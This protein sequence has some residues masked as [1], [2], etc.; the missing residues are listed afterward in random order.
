MFYKYILTILIFTS[1]SFASFQNVKIGRIDSYYKNKISKEELKTIIE[2]IEIFFES[3]L[4]INVFD[5][6]ATGKSINLVYVP[7]SKLENRIL[8]YVQ[9]L[10]LKEKEI[11]NLHKSFPMKQKNIDK[12]KNMF[13]QQN[14]LLN[15]RVKSLNDYVRTVNKKKKISKNEYNDVQRYVKKEKR[16]LEVGIKKLRKEEQSIK[17]R[18]SSFNKSV[19]SYNNLILVHKRLNS[20]LEVMSRGFKKVK[21]MTFGI[22][23]IRLKTFYKNGKKVKEKSVK[24]SMN[25]I[26][27]YGFETKG[28]LKAI[29]A[30]EILHLVGIPHI[31]IKNSLMHPV[32][33]KNQI[34]QIN[35]PKADILNFKKYF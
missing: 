31:N 6:S 24:N 3:K 18:V 5:Y 10:K 25:K 2:E 16:K 26:D 8:D 17:K 13:V 12:L 20:Q 22:K 27:I 15:K 9:K 30:H 14:N 35:L 33:Q 7:A 4:N 29:L 11:T 23:E 34:K 32:L 19:Y 21:G 28:E 1:L